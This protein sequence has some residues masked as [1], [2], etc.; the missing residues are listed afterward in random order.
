MEPS[1]VGSMGYHLGVGLDRGRA[2]EWLGPA[3]LPRIGEGGVE[4]HDGHGAGGC[5]RDG[6]VSLT[7]LTQAKR[8]NGAGDGDP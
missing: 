6:Q 8:R 3:F 5:V 1:G 4:V 2:D 7:V